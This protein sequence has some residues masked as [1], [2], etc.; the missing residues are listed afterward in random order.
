VCSVFLNTR[1]PSRDSFEVE[2]PC[3]LSKAVERERHA[4]FAVMAAYAEAIV[5]KAAFLFIAE[6]AH[7]PLH[8]SLTSFGIW[9]NQPGNRRRGILDSR[10]KEFA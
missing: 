3:P 4:D 2:V 6:T 7:E 1:R 5:V 9:E 10:R 8:P